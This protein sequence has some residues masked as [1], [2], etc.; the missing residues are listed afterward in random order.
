VLDSD[1]ARE[2]LM[3]AGTG[4]GLWLLRKVSVSLRE[5]VSEFQT[6]RELPERMEN[7]MRDVTNKFDARMSAN[8][9]RQEILEAQ[10]RVV[11]DRLLQQ[12]EEARVERCANDT[13]A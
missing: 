4:V 3:T 9:R 11:V 6:L 5:M 10:F 8:E 2:I 13:R 1:T 12:R 7:A